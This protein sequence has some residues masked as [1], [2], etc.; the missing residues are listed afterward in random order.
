MSRKAPERKDQAQKT[1][2]KTEATKGE[3]HEGQLDKV[4]GGRK[5]GHDQQEFMTV[6]MKDAL[7]TSVR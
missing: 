1:P 6:T 4:V 2:A 5:A 3:L 7:I